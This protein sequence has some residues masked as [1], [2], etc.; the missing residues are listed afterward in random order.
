MIY[1]HTHTHTHYSTLFFWGPATGMG[2]GVPTQPMRLPALGPVWFPFH[3]PLR[4]QFLPTAC[5][6]PQDSSPM[7]SQEAYKVVAGAFQMLAKIGRGN[8]N[9]KHPLAWKLHGESS[10]LGN[11]K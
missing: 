4:E 8:L 9:N 2:C 10:Y 11:T 3:K 5:E 6:M 7:A 1:K